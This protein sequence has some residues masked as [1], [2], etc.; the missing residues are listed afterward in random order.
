ML[1]LLKQLI[2]VLFLLSLFS[3]SPKKV[4]DIQEISRV[5]NLV[6]LKEDNV[7]L[8]YFDGYSL[9]F[10]DEVTRTGLK[11]KHSTQIISSIHLGGVLG[12]RATSH[13]YLS[14]IK[15]SAQEYVEGLMNRTFEY[16]KNNDVINHS[17]IIKELNEWRYDEHIPLIL[18]LSTKNKFEKKRYFVFELEKE[19]A[20]VLVVWTSLGNAEIINHADNVFEDIYKTIEK[21]E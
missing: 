6:N 11:E 13:V 18:D 17:N 14:I 5:Y 4:G 2:F 9:S 15:Y 21:I 7:R 19:R 8:Y 3:C 20:L 10:Q 16:L 1:G 12:D